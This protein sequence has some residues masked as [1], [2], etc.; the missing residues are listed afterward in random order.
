KV[1]AARLRLQRGAELDLGAQVHRRDR[2]HTLYPCID[3]HVGKRAI[4]ENAQAVQA[5]S[6]N[7]ARAIARGSLAALDALERKYRSVEQ[8]AHLVGEHAETLGCL[9]RDRV[10]PLTRV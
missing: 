5:A 6:M 8:V 2:L 9:I 1:Q 10:L 4:D 7:G 3:A